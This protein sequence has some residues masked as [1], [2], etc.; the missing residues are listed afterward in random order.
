LR[1]LTAMTVCGLFLLAATVMVIFTA[2]LSFGQTQT[3][4]TPLGQTPLGQQASEQTTFEQMT[5][6]QATFEQQLRKAQRLEKAGR[7]EESLQIYRSLLSHRPED[8]ELL[9][10]IQGIYRELK[11]YPQLIEMIQQRLQKDPGDFEL[12]IE[13]GEAYF[14]SGDLPKARDTWMEALTTAP[15]QESSFSR[16]SDVFLERG[17]LPEAEDILLQGRQVL[18][19]ETLFAD[20]LARIHELR[21][22]YGAATREYLL[23][24]RQ[25]A[26]RLNYVG[27]QL[28]RFPDQP[29]VHQAVERAL[30]EAVNEASVNRASVDR[31]S[32]DRASLDRAPDEQVFRQLLS[33]YLIRTGQTE[34]AYVEVLE[35]E[36]RGDPGGQLLIAFAARCAELGFHQT[37]IRACR[38]VLARHPE[39]PAAR[40][41]QLVIGRSL[42]ALQR[43][44]QALL[45]Y[46]DLLAGQPESSEAVEALYGLGEIYFLHGR[47][48]NGGS[49]DGGA[50]GGLTEGG[51]FNRAAID[52][53][54]AAYQRL[55]DRYGRSARAADAALRIGE[56]LVIKGDM[57]GARD[58]YGRLAYGPG[59]EQVR[60]EA[61][62]R[63]AELLFLEGRIEESRE[64]LD[65]LVGGYPQ[66]FT[67][68]DALLLSLLIDEASAENE[69]A[70]QTF[71]GAM[72]LAR[73]RRYQKALESF[74]RFG[75]QFPSSPLMDDVLMQRALIRERLGRYDEALADLQDLIAEYPE[76]RLCPQALRHIGEIYE[77]RL[78]DLPAAR[79]TYE[80]LLSEYPNYLFLNEVRRTLRRLKGQETG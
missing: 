7:L 49:P 75:E 57:E 63:L 45:A 10:R 35:L 52:S 19:D 12:R 78:K 17:L 32:I 15:R 5:S 16:V 67:V 64:A 73:Q 77:H 31:A 58:A 34:E 21:A 65:N 9:S 24:L 4:Q 26:R 42:V 71:S 53:A 2:T 23:W 55:I 18:A 41:A 22:D 79:Q 68:N 27:A 8:R 80:R 62:Y 48:L 28:A 50:N 29:E 54:Q 20:R 44:D 13:L 47:A 30:R 59:P 70:L 61:A 37:A 39:T 38:E 76:S 14:L 40:Q 66:G 33:Q 60:E 43:Y 3:K 11:W 72:L 46:R 56:C 36:K 1:Q 51:F 74:E 6:E 69:S 25:D